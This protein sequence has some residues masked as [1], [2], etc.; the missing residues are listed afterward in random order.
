[1]PFVSLYTT[2]ILPSST[3]SFPSILACKCFV[4][5]FPPWWWWKTLPHCSLGKPL[6]SWFFS[7][8]Q[9]QGTLEIVQWNPNYL[10]VLMAITPI[11]DFESLCRAYTA[12]TYATMLHTIV[13]TRSINV[14]SA[15]AFRYPSTRNSFFFVYYGSILYS[16]TQKYYHCQ[17]TRSGT[18]GQI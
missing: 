18:F 9:T 12:S 11:C 14:W 3:I 5:S 2:W 15:A 6:V 17:Y 8:W 13:D 1:M 7:W 16:C 10:S 4:H